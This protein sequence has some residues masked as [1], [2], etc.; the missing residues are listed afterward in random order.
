MNCRL[1]LLRRYPVRGGFLSNG[2]AAKKFVKNHRALS[3]L[4]GGVGGGDDAAAATGKDQRAH[5]DHHEQTH[6]GYQSVPKSEKESMVGSVFRNVADQYDLMN[7]LMSGGVHRCWKQHFMEVLSPAEDTK[8]LDVAGGTGDIAFRFI[9]SVRK[10]S[11]LGE[12]RYTAKVTV[13]DINDEM[14]RVGQD[15][16]IK[17]GYA[18]P[19]IEWI[20]ANAEQLPL[21]DNTFD[22]Y[23][24][25]F[26]I[27]NCTNIDRVLAEAYR[28]LKPGGRFLCL[29]FGRV[30]NPVVR[31]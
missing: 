6:F 12:S 9:D 1:Q 25:S 10:R 23:T 26:G 29:E 11:Y 3:Q 15:R 7:D 16:A 2:F 22:A 18:G 8:L 4:S 24:I 27:R 31:R 28:V 5:D 13:L 14:L 30:E 20:C 21:P 17:R 19:E